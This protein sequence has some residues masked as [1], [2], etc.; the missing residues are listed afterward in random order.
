MVD[1]TPAERLGEAQALS[2]SRLL[3]EMLDTA[4]IAYGRVSTMAELEAHRSLATTEVQTPEGPVTVI[5]TTAVIDG[6]RAEL[7]RVPACGEHS[8]A[9]RHEFCAGEQTRSK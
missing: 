9:I 1:M 2:E 6:R 8:A 4:R 7:G 3:R 5:A